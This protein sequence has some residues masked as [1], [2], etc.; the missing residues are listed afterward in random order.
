MPRNLYLSKNLAVLLYQMN[1]VGHYFVDHGVQD[2]D[3]TLGKILPDLLRNFSKSIRLNASDLEGKGQGEPLYMGI[4]MHFRTDRVFHDSALFRERSAEINGRLKNS[5]L[6]IRKYRF[7]FAHVL[8]EMLIDRCLLIRHPGLGEGFYHQ[9][10]AADKQT[11]SD[12]FEAQGW[13]HLI[14]GFW[15]FLQR[16]ISSE[17][18]LQYVH[19]ESLIFALGRIGERVGL[20]SAVG[21]ADEGLVGLIDSYTDTLCKELPGFFES[22]TKKISDDDK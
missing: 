18:L 20:K 6:S 12:F 1:F 4:R 5:V 21:M 2:A 17:Y 16:F 13:L 14:D 22:L 19:N 10:A 8:L 11:L 9:L 15:A 3:Y 7:F